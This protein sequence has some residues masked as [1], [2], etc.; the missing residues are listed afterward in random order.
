MQRVNL[1]DAVEHLKDLVDAAIRGD[2]IMIVSRDQQ[3][4]QLV[5]VTSVNLVRKFGSAAGLVTMSDDFDAPLSD[6][7]G[8]ME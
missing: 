3:T 6:F 2:T 8:Y 5:P 7:A 4:M 1:D